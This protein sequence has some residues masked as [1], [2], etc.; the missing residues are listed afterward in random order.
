MSLLPASWVF[1]WMTSH[2]ECLPFVL[3]LTA[4][5]HLLYFC[6]N[7]VAGMLVPNL[8]DFYPTVL[9]SILSCPVTT[10]LHGNLACCLG[11]LLCSS[12]S[13]IEFVDSAPSSIFYMEQSVPATSWRS[14][15]SDERKQPLSKEMS[16][17]N[18]KRIGREIFKNDK[19]ETKY[20]F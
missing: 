13:G 16:E 11:N 14:Y 9:T 5:K 12:C 1:V 4:W 10:G 2:S 8:T 7:Y 3:S 19:V 15:C 17:K 6:L 18:G 20:M